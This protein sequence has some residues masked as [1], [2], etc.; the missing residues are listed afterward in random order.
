M[1]IDSHHHLWNYSAEE[2][3]WISDQMSV[4]KRDFTPTDLGE[5]GSANGIDGFVS[6]QARQT[7]GETEWLLGLA[8]HHD[9]IRG[10][11]GWVPLAEA[12]AREEIERWSHSENLKAVRHV[13][14]DEPDDAFILGDDFNRGIGHLKDYGLV[15]DILIFAKHLPNTLQFV[16][17]HPEQAFILDHIAKPTIRGNEFD[18]EW[19]KNI[20]ELAKRPNVMCK[21]SGVVTEVRDEAWSPATVQRYWDVAWDAFGAE[22]LMYG[23]D[24]PVCLLKTEYSR[25]VATVEQLASSLSIQE[26]KNFWALNAI[27]GYNL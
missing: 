10:V 18:L 9:L 13:V 16:D 15:Y 19:E 3:G 6:V 12:N 7:I 27:R 20:R 5:I 25:W 23:S 8:E 2:Y 21:F 17:R 4:L 14:Q 22:R 24:W 26:K 1:R 11:V